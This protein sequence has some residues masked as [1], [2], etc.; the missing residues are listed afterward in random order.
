IIAYTSSF[1]RRVRSSRYTINAVNS[2]LLA[3]KIFLE[4][5]QDNFLVSSVIFPVSLLEAISNILGYCL[6][7][8][9]ELHKPI[10]RLTTSST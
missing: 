6:T 9:E 8:S 5:A 3:I 4:I 7:S 1:I 10:L 2:K